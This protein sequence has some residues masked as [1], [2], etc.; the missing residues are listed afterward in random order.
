SESILWSFGNGSDGNFPFASLFMDSNGNLYG[1]TR[2][3]GTYG[4][5]TAFK[6]APPSTIGETW[7]ESILWSFGNGNDGN[8]PRAGLIMDSNGNLYGTT[9]AGGNFPSS[10]N[11]DAECGGT[12]FKLTP[13]TTAG[14]PWTEAILWNFGNGNDGISPVSGLTMDGSGNL[15]GATSS[16]GSYVSASVVG[17]TVFELTPPS[18]SGENWTEAILW[19]FGN[20]NDGENPRAG[21]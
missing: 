6:L 11:N 9:S 15:Y 21:L 2:S 16:G 12:V 10:C 3:G 13:P 19:N 8:D 17:G 1:T 7:A 18:T 14:E 20:G 4:G 5:G